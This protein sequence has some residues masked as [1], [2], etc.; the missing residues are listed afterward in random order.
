MRCLL[1]SCESV[2]ILDNKNIFTKKISVKNIFTN[3]I[4]K[5]IF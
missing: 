2:K 4:P 3:N 1:N 5:N